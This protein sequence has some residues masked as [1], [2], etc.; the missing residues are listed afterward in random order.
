MTWIGARHYL[1]AALAALLVA[2]GPA[3]AS[4]RFVAGDVQRVDS[5]YSYEE[6]RARLERAAARSD[7]TL[8][9]AP[10]RAATSGRGIPVITIGHGPRRIL[11]TAMQHGNEYGVSDAAVRLASK[12][13]SRA[14]SAG[15]LRSALTVAIMPR[16]NVD[17]FDRTTTGE[18]WR[19]NVDSS[20]SG[21]FSFAGRGYDINRYHPLGETE[22]PYLPGELNPVP[23]ALAVRAVFEQL[24]PEIFLDL[25]HQPIVA[26]NVDGPPVVLGLAWPTVAGA[27]Q[28]VIDQSK[29]V[30]Y[31][32]YVALKR[33][34][35]GLYPATPDASIARNRYGLLGAASVLLEYRGLE[36]F[37][38]AVTGFVTCE[39]G[40]RIEDSPAVRRVVR[41]TVMSV[42]RSAET[43][44]L[45]T[46]DPALAD[47][48]ILPYNTQYPVGEA[49]EE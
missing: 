16:V 49:D 48:S 10:Y 39:G 2:V 5:I 18:P 14:R 38:D 40:G 7:T 37:A 12:L 42:L 36:C 13:T 44:A 4:P 1:T 33:R 20:A 43:G 24:R 30:A 23:E 29:R 21:P 8:V 15:R 31:A 17:G 22:N 41:D 35:G 45:D 28:S 19:P 27:Q 9:D 32:A 26:G 34:R 25:H 46:L 11:I 47:A 6:L 3:G